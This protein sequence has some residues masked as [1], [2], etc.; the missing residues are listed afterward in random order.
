MTRVTLFIS[1]LLILSAVR[2]EVPAPEFTP[3][4]YAFGYYGSSSADH[5]AEFAPGGHDPNRDG[6]LVL[7]SL[8]PSLSLRWGEYVEGFVTGLAYTDMED[9]LE[10]HWEEY[11]LK[12][13]NLP[14][15]LELRGGRM[16]S[17][18]GFHNP[19]HLHSWTAVDAPLVN[20]LFLG[21][22]G[23]AL[24]GA[25]LSM[26]FGDLN[27]TVVTL[28]FGNA[29]SHDHD[30]GHSDDDHEEH[31]EDHDHEEHDH[32][33][34]HDDHE[35]EDH[36]DHGHSHEGFGGFEEY[37]P[38]DDVFTLGIRHDRFINDFQQLR[39]AGFGGMGDSE[40]GETSWFAGA[41]VEYQWRENGLEP[42]GRAVRWRTEAILFEGEAGSHDHDEDHDHDH[43]EEHDDDHDEDH[44]EH[45]HGDE[46]GEDVSSWGLTTE[47]VFEATE[48]VHPFA[49]FDYIA[50]TDGLDLEDWTRYSGGVTF[51]LTQEPHVQLRLQANADE[52]GD[53]SEQSFWAQ[54]GFSWGGPEVR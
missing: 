51:H 40:I 22:D 11:F 12:F 7:Q 42:G 8:E 53:E 34:E 28:G 46:H 41:G 9:D 32:D 29:P 35:E 18:V 44:E 49:R 13:T 3:S 45:D 43:E 1:S 2:A 5:P 20:S 36:D 25:D 19:T 30:H 14:G 10:W 16:L 17:R 52:Q 37:R 33:A 15:G 24:E 21:E 23:L 27:P 48:R 50:S 6:D 38:A 26:Y 4:L 31:G 47:V 39:F 54:L